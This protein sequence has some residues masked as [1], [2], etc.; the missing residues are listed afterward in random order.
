MVNI[1]VNIYFWI[2][3]S[4]LFLAMFGL[5]LI[6][7]IVLAKKTHAMVELKA[8]TKGVPISQFYMDNRYC[9]WLPI[10]PEA[11]IIQHKDYGSFIVNEKA[12]YVDK[13]TKNIFIPFD[14]AFAAS[15]N[16]HAAKLADDMQYLAH[17]EETLK[18]LRHLISTNQID[19]SESIDVLKT[20]VHFGAMKTMM[21][22][23]IPHNINAKIEKTISARLKGV[24]SFNVW[25]PVTVFL[26][27]FGAIVLGIFLMRM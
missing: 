6:F 18:K 19:D 9:E 25:T 2:V 26:A 16:V 1:L 15:I 13:R 24:R 12:T 20:S 11:G 22:A 5:L 4:F 21:T 14:S 17:D 27:M 23:L 7:L 10:K 3:M 8:W